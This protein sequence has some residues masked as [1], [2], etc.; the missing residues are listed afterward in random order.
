VCVVNLT[1]PGAPPS[2]P[3]PHLVR[4]ETH[5]AAQVSVALGADPPLPMTMAAG[6]ATIVVPWP[7]T[8][9]PPATVHATRAATAD[10]FALTLTPGCQDRQ[11]ALVA[12]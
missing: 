2:L 10:S 3:T 5:D 8:T 9:A 4:V 6:T 7:T 11:L 1:P 12:A